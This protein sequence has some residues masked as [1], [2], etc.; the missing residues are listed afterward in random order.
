MPSLDT[1]PRVPLAHLPTPLEE[2]PRLAAAIGVRRLWVKRDDC[3]GLA[4]GGNKA[5]KLEFLVAEAL[6]QGA[7]TLLTRGG[8]Q[9]NHARMTAAAACRHGLGAIL[10]F[11]DARPPEA[12]GNLL[13]DRLFGAECRFFPGAA[14]A[15]VDVEVAAGAAEVARRGR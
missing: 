14:Y 15:A 5:R 10:F 8:V 3:T 2:A 11:T 12:Q 1:F 7:D 9:S 6:A 4:M 13:L